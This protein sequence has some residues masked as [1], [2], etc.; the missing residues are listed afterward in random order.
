MKE[1]KLTELR[2]KL[3]SLDERIV[4]L[5]NERA[6]VAGQIGENKKKMGKEIYDPVQE[7]KVYERI[8]AFNCG[9]LS[10]EALK[11]I[12]RE[13]ISAAR[14]LQSPITVSF[15]GPEA[16]FSHLAALNHFGKSALYRPEGSIG[17]VFDA[18]E[19]EKT[20]WGVVPIENSIEGPVKP[21][22]DHLIT[23]PLS[24]RAEIFLRISH[25]LYSREGEVRKI[26]HI[27][28]HPQALAQCQGWIKKNLPRAKL[29]EESSTSEAAV[30]AGKEKGAGAIC[31]P[32]AA[33]RNGLKKA[34]EG[35][36]D[37]PMNTTRFLVMGYGS[38]APS[39]RDKTSIIFG[40]PHVPGSLHRALTP[41][42]RMGINLTRIASYPI[43]ERLWEYVFFVDFLGHEDEDPVRT[44]LSELKAIASFVKQLGSYPL[45]EEP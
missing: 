29:H 11:E 33:E 10:N 19:K 37:H 43:R 12:Y 36:E 1:K 40:T 44:C 17:D 15:L 20:K 38:N 41:F 24:I 35:I 2:K 13:I 18:V 7:A 9:P 6:K 32:L 4:S 42:A 8:C 26:K 5:L 16:S 27:Y 14:A 3:S 45:G 34:A 23:T 22:L 28:S 30:M 31:T 39:G 25:T 21:T